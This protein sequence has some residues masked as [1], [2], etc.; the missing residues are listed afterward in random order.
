[1]HITFINLWICICFHIISAVTIGFQRDSYEFV[2]NSS[3]PV[4]VNII[5][6]GQNAIPITVTLFLEGGSAIGT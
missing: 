2:E 3:L 5:K 6:Q 1:M 4:F